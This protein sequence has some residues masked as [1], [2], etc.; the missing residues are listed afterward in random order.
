[1]SPRLLF[2]VAALVAICVVLSGCG[3]G[4]DPKPTPP[5]VGEPLVI[6]EMLK[7]GNYAQAQKMSKVDLSAW[8]W[9]SKAAMHSGFMALDPRGSAQNRETF[10]WYSAAQKDVQT[11]EAAGEDLR[12][13]VSQF[14]MLFPHLRANDLYITGESYAGK[15]VPAAAYTIHTFNQAATKETKINLKGISIGDGAMDPGAQFQGFGDLLWYMGMV[16][17]SERKKFQEYEATIQTKLGNDDNEGAFETFDE[18][19]NGDFYPYPT[20]YANV[21]GMTTNYFNMQLAP[22]ATPLGGDFVDWLNTP[23]VRAKIHVGGRS[24]APEN[25]TVEFQLKAAWMQGVVPMLVPLMENYKVLIY[26]GQNDV[27]L[28]PPLTEQ[29][30]LT[31]DWS[32]KDKYAS[33][34]KTVWRR[35]DKGVGSK[36]PD[37]CG[38]V[39]TVGNFTQAVVRGAGHMVP[40]DQPER[41]LDLMHH[42]ISGTPF[43]NPKANGEKV[44]SLGA[45]VV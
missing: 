41:A 4:D 21:T 34:P 27:I 2:G 31:L 9:N 13:A 35:S 17:S 36:L 3:G 18:M 7:A 24:Y 5:D 45:V 28:G 32:G 26:S 15:W 22:D 14:F 19:L 16:D 1:M 38:Y 39:R 37:V 11:H 29:F 33:A 6:T 40:G 30:L 12:N 20:Y 8:G 23:E 25:Q 42:F 43:S 10:F 44:A